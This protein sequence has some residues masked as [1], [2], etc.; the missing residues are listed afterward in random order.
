MNQNIC[1]FLIAVLMSCSHKTAHAPASDTRATPPPRPEASAPPSSEQISFHGADSVARNAAI[2]PNQP[3]FAIVP[4]TSTGASQNPPAK[5]DGLANRKVLS[6]PKMDD[7]TQK[8][9]KVVVEVCVDSQGNVI[10]ADYTMRG[11]TTNDP[12]L[13]HKA[14][15]WAR[16][17]KFEPSPVEQQ[18]GNMTFNFQLK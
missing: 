15:E 1:L 18:C 7:N 11:S 6:R 9:G 14:I 4:S 2:P 8:T 17:C 13:I 12:E 16:Q 5:S 10:S 3:D